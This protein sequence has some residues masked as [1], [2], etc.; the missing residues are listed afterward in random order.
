MFSE[1]LREALTEEVV[2]QPRAI[3]SVVRS[4]TRLSSGLTPL[5]RT[6]CAHLFLGP[7]GTGRA[8]LARTLARHL[9]GADV[10]HTVCCNSGRQADPWLSF[11]QQLEPLFSTQELHLLT[12]GGPPQILLV[13]D[14]EFAHKELFP[15]LARLLETG[16]VALPG[17][18]E[19]RLHNCMIFLISGLCS[20]KILET[21]EI[22]FAG[23]TFPDDGGGLSGSIVRTCSAEA[24]RSFGLELLAQLDDFVVFQ[25]LEQEH[26]E[27]VLRGHFARLNRWFAGRGV[28]CELL[29]RASAFLLERGSLQRLLGARD[30]I[31]IHRREV[32]F[33]LAD[34]LISGRLEG[35]AHVVIDHEP[36]AKH[37]HFTVSD[38]EATSEG[39]GHVGPLLEIPV[40]V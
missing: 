34:L 21:N 20:D 7:P 9:H 38:P 13:Q 24:E 39:E 22:G 31:S 25:R 8:H 16:K 1:R 4:V 3:Q 10:V 32:E 33:P 36:G 40:T 6:W 35:G 12:R 37:L 15:L 28:R 11:V 5:E 30:L 14:L 19:G 17:R 27:R 2:G 29:P 23:S 18:R 26:L